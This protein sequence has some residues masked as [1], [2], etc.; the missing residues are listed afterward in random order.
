MRIVKMKTIRGSDKVQCHHVC[1]A[2]R[3]S[4]NSLV[5]SRGGTAL[6]ALA[7]DPDN[8]PSRTTSEPSTT[9]ADASKHTATSNFSLPKCACA[10]SNASS[11][12][13]SPSDGPAPS[14]PFR[15]TNPGPCMHV[16]RNPGPLKRLVHR[17]ELP[18]PRLLGY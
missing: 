3:P 16:L 18:L 2:A 5:A 9:S 8:P 17:C 12:D 1:H 15:I 6:K 14:A 11:T 10:L 4:S 7:S 13:A